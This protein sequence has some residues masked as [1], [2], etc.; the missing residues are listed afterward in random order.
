MEKGDRVRL[1]TDSTGGGIDYP[2]DT[3]GYIVSLNPPYASWEDLVEVNFYGYKRTLI[4]STSKLEVIKE[5]NMK[6]FKE[7]LE[8]AYHS[9]KKLENEWDK[10]DNHEKATI[11]Q[12]GEETGFFISEHLNEFLHDYK[13][14]KDQL[15]DVHMIDGYTVFINDYGE[16]VVIIENDFVV[17]NE[18]NHL[19][20]LKSK[21]VPNKS[22]RLL[23]NF[24]ISQL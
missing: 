19:N 21:G 17:V 4:V 24:Y 16:M 18:F 13:K 11:E 6:K 10:L 5:G 7:Q 12:V 15:E 2:K 9:M 23:T 1:K 8:L 3:I 22:I 20:S 14:F